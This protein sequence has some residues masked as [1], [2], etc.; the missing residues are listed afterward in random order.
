MLLKFINRVDEIDTLN[1]R[2]KSNKSEFLVIYG[3]R[4][5]GKTELIK[6]FAKDKKHFYFL[7][8]K[9]PIELEVDR[10][11]K[12][13]SE[14]FNIYLRDTKDF[15]T[16][17]KEIIETI[18]TSQKFIFII[19]EFPY[20]IEQYKPILSI[21][22]SIWDEV[23]KKENVFL[24]L[25]GSSVSMMETEVIGY[26][27]PLYGR[28]TGQLKIEPIKIYYLKEFLPYYKT[29]DLLKT[30]GATGGIPFYLKEFDSKKSFLK[31]IF[32]TFFNKSNILYQEAEILLKE[33]LREPNTYFN[34]LK[35]MID[36]ATKLSEIS[37]KSLV[38]VTNINKYISVL[39]TLKLV[40]KEYPITEP[41]K[42]RNFIYKV[43][44][45]YFR[46]WLSYVYPYKEEIEEDPKSVLDFVKTEYPQYMGE[47]FEETIRRYL[48]TLISVDFNKV[49]KWWQKEEEIDV[50]GLNENKKHII[51]LECKWSN[52]SYNQSL[53][54]LKKL[55]E[56]ADLVQWLNDK[57]K[58]YYGLAARKIENKKSLKD[59]GFLV[60]DLDD[61]N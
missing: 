37:A 59:E 19:D 1:K 15:E 28:R 34:I 61:W 23:L 51:Y 48:R 41:A 56:K 14:K 21:F 24:I 29:E 22:Q 55:K 43:D 57:R 18:D 39:E 7:A 42:L 16:L 52:L 6:Q 40:R 8:R 38:D 17:F 12:K 5:I 32:D 53:K 10:F 11:R 35:A 45:N 30:F 27:S 36:G 26:K 13:I 60:Y 58:E 50:V 25:T 46:F 20:F 2:Y 44:D 33:T 3:R 47:I 4:R 9:E 31:N 54:L 49:G